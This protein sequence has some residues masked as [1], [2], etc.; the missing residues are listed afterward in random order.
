MTDQTPNKSKILQKIE[1]CLALSTSSN[2]N[3]AATALRQAQ[4]LMQMHSLSMS[5]VELA[6]L[7]VV[8]TG[9]HSARPPRWRKILIQAVSAAFS[10]SL[11]YRRGNPVF[12][13]VDPAPKIA[14]YALEVLLRQLNLNKTEYLEGERFKRK[15]SRSKA[16]KLGKG[17]AEGWAIV[18]HTVVDE[19]A[20][21]ITETQIQKHKDKLLEHI[22]G[23]RIN[24]KTTK[25]KSALASKDGLSAAQHGHYDGSKAQ[26]HAGMSTDRAQLYIESGGAA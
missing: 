19:F 11:F 3:E 12:V 8:E 13:G 7:S 25:H 1:R 16:I 2:A 5:D 22:G 6:K 17:Y 21:P 26:I 10:C 23:G 20:M 24:Q 4:K 18:C 15:L 14:V 9:E